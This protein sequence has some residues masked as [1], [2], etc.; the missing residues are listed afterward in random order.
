MPS[1]DESV[2]SKRRK[3]DTVEECLAYE[4]VTENECL[5]DEKVKKKKRR[6]REREGF[7]LILFLFFCFL[8][9]GSV[10]ELGRYENC[11]R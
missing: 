10:F 6:G 1:E 11:P 4:K 7:V 5:A 8:F 2:V 9:I 3:R